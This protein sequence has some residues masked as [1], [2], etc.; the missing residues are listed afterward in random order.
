MEIWLTKFA[1]SWNQVDPKGDP[2]LT[3]SARDGE[4]KCPRF[5]D[6]ASIMAAFF[7]RIRIT[8]ILKDTL[9]LKEGRLC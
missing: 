6:D 3:S 4:N 7:H 5:N 9:T 2:G 8:L 1:K